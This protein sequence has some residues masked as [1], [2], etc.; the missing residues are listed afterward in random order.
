MKIRNGFVSNSSSSSFICEISGDIESGYDMSI[1][2]AGMYECENGHIFNEDY[3][4][5]NLDKYIENEYEKDDD[6]DEYNL[7]YSLPKEFCPICQM[8][9]IGKSDLEE[10]LIKLSGKSKEELQKEIKL[11]FENYD[12]FKKYLK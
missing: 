6:F 9:E 11:S 7:R 8:K 10:Y 1:D 3:A 2:E 5:D 4:L 12:D